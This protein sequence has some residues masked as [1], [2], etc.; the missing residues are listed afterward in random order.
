MLSSARH[1]R[2]RVLELEAELG[3]SKNFALVG[4]VERGQYHSNLASADYS[5]TLTSVLF[6]WRF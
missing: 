1:D 5:E 2:G 6:K 3:L 4:K